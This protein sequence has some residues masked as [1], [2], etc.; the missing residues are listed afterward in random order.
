[1]M[2]DQIVDYSNLRD[3]TPF[4]Y[5]LDSELAWNAVE[6]A[7]VLVYSRTNIMLMA[8]LLILASRVSFFARPKH[9]D[10]EILIKRNVHARVAVFGPAFVFFKQLACDGRESGSRTHMPL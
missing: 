3:I 7:D 5:L 10:A 4:V 9:L 1:M 8:K 2:G 6:D